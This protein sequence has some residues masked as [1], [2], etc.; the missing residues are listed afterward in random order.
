MKTRNVSFWRQKWLLRTKSTFGDFVNMWSVKPGIGSKF[1][2]FH[3]NFKF[4][5]VSSFSSFIY[6]PTVFTLYFNH[7]YVL[8]WPLEEKKVESNCIIKTVFHPSFFLCLYLFTI[9]KHWCQPTTIWQREMCNQTYQTQSGWWSR[10]TKKPGGGL[11][12]CLVPA[13]PE[14][15][16]QCGGRKSPEPRQSWGRGLR[17][18]DKSLGNCKWNQEAPPSNLKAFVRG[19]TKNNETLLNELLHHQHWRRRKHRIIGGFGIMPT[20]SPKYLEFI[21][22]FSSIPKILFLHLF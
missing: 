8:K 1:C 16:K 6:H 12:S 17:Q 22:Q 11:G 5:F 13:Q 20:F 21:I 10:S 7:S 19:R 2:F 14:T 4:F 15:V 18:N 9:I 3:H